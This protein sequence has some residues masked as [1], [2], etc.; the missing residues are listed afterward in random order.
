MKSVIKSPLALVAVLVAAVALSDG[1]T[2]NA[3]EARSGDLVRQALRSG[4][5][6]T[7]FLGDLSKREVA[8]AL[9]NDMCEPGRTCR[10]LVAQLFFSHSCTWSLT[11]GFIEIYDERRGG[12][13]PYDKCQPLSRPQI[14]LQT[15]CSNSSHY[16]R[17]LF[18]SSDC[19]G[20]AFKEETHRIANCLQVGGGPASVYWCDAKD[21]YPL[22]APS[23]PP[24]VDKSVPLAPN[25]HDQCAST[26]VTAPPAG[27]PVDPP[28]TLNG[29]CDPRFAIARTNSLFSR[30]TAAN[31]SVPLSGLD[32]YYVFGKGSPH[33][34]YQANDFNVWMAVDSNR[35]TVNYGI[36][37]DMT[38]MPAY[39]DTTMFGCHFLEAGSD[40]SHYTR[41]GTLQ[42]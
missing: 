3:L 41:A 15:S 37:C 19:T 17:S 31:C 35:I 25:F 1:G 27:G 11:Y 34:C 14:A 2:V 29:A 5:P 38:Q 24:Q 16:T 18:E 40:F 6:W 36:G 32:S 10:G 23:S 39:S 7:H 22:T 4:L 12:H 8:S 20:I 26:P 33:T 28:T 42:V 21:S 9:E 13:T 30:P